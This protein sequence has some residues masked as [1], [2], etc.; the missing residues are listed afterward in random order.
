M[1]KHYQQVHSKLNNQ[2]KT[3]QLV[4]PKNLQKPLTKM[5]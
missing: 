3:V 4:T 5:N 2:P 1:L